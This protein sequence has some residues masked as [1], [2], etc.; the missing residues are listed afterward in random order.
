MISFFSPPSHGSSNS[1]TSCNGAQQRSFAVKT[2]LGFISLCS[3]GDPGVSVHL[4]GQQRG[5]GHGRPQPA[6]LRLSA[7]PHRQLPAL[8]QHSDRPAVV[9]AL[10]CGV[11]FRRAAA[12]RHG[13]VV[14]GAGGDW[15]V[16]REE[17][18]GS[19]TRIILPET[20]SSCVESARLCGRCSSR[21]ACL[22]GPEVV[23][24]WIWA[25]LYVFF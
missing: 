14:P 21:K 19:L 20:K 7:G 24:L 12:H 3:Q 8:L 18:V 9:G 11:E 6:L 1:R 16:R 22:S 13:A 25:L 15:Q 5:R 10:R 2:P 4:T 17:V 23:Q